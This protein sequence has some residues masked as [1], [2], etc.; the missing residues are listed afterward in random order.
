MQ[1]VSAV[2]NRAQSR[3]V[4]RVP[5]NLVEID[6]RIEFSAS[7]YPFVDLLTHGFFLRSIERDLRR[8]EE[9]VLERRIRRPN[10]S[11]SFFV[12]AR[13]ELAIAGYDAFGTNAFD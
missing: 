12:R 4:A 7:E 11:D 10:D 13:Y 8:S 5:H 6:H 1:V 2:V 3:R 9:R